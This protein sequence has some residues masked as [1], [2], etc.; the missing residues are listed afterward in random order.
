M[1]KLVTLATQALERAHAA[2]RDLPD[3]NTFLAKDAEECAS[4]AVT[5]VASHWELQR[6]GKD[7]TPSVEVNNADNERA[8][9]FLA[10]I[11]DSSDDAIIGETSDG[12]IISWNK[13]AERIFGYE[14][15]EICGNSATLLIPSDRVGEEGAILHRIRQGERPAHFESVRRRKDGSDVVAS[16]T[17]SPIHDESSGI[18]GFSK[19]V[20][21]ITNQRAAQNRLAELQSELVHAL[22]LGTLGQ[23]AAAISHELNQPLTA[24]DNYLSGLTRLLSTTDVDPSV[25]DA[26]NK[27]RQ[28]NQRS[29]EIAR[30]LRD[31]AGKRET[32]RRLESIN[33]ILEETLGLA[34]VDAKVRGVR[35]AVLL[36]PDL[37]PVFVDKIQIS[38][39]IINIIRNA[40]EAMD[41]AV[42]RNLTISTGASPDR[43]GIEI[44]I[45]DTGP[46][47]SPQIK[48]RLFQPFVTT[49]DNGMGLGL[50]I[51]HDIIDSHGGS[52]SA[53]LNDPQ[54]TIFLIRLPDA[55]TP[56]SV[57]S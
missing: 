19:I 55:D 33:E 52:L 34:L 29:G 23:M 11:V 47:L 42:E 1:P 45:A 3:T 12:I 16:L 20:R 51:C 38:Q 40:I 56:I 17:I 28:Q 7:R 15:A 43:H 48:E 50:S 27:A 54:G 2:I 44:R 37:G 26:L 4:G 36:A 46:G 22:R 6:D 14:A 25:T 57:Y 18:V 35:T 39:V 13:A 31:L 5:D 21:D 30:Q 24:V 49:K 10:S 9:A 53:E 32:T 41:G 8:R